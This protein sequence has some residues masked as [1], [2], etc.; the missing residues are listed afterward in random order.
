MIEERS[1]MLSMAI[2]KGAHYS[3]FRDIL[4]L[5]EKLNFGAG[6]AYDGTL[7]RSRNGVLDWK[8]LHCQIYIFGIVSVTLKYPLLEYDY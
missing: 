6:A 1:D 2:Q 8:I 3:M 7:M 4:V 5:D